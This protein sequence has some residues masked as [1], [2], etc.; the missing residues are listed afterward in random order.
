MLPLQIQPYIIDIVNTSPTFAYP[1]TI[2]GAYE[3]L[4]Y[5]NINS[6][7]TLFT[8]TQISADANTFEYIEDV[9]LFGFVRSWRS[10]RHFDSSKSQLSIISMSF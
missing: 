6:N 4:A 9:G 7:L 8:Y 1:V 3:T 5:T 10:T 2:L